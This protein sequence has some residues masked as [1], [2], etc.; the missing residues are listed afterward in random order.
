MV[1]ISKTSFWLM[2]IITLSTTDNIDGLV[3]VLY[4]IVLYCI[5]LYCV[6]HCDDFGFRAFSYLSRRMSRYPWP[7]KY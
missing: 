4:Y 3:S 5:V 6:L 7:S 2:I 1:L